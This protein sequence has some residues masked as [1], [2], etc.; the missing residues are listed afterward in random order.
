MSD[1]KVAIKLSTLEN[2]GNAVRNKEGTTD[3]IPVNT[4]A[5]RIAALPSGVSKL[6]QII[7]RTIT[8]ITAEDLVGIT[9]IGRYAFCDC[10]SLTSV[11]IPDS[12]TSISSYPFYNCTS[13]TSVTIGNGVTSIGDW[14]FYN[15]TSLMS[16]TI[17]DSVISIGG[18]MFRGCSS[19]TSVTIGNGVTSISRN[20]FDSCTSLTSVIIPDS[21][22]SISD[23]AFSYCTSLTS[24][25]IP[26]SVTSISYDAL[27][28]GSTSNTATITFLRT[29]PPSIASSTFRTDYLDKIIVP[30]G[31][32]EAYKTAT[33]WA[34]FA[35]Y[36]EEATE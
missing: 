34:N 19:L 20:M 12:V 26:D 6:P 27:K 28:I 16:V 10:A 18:Q 13:L 3:L 24:V 17:P 9:K 7:D 30:A 1:K 8:E 15:C 21:V 36:I 14:V 29:T 25:I 33:N 4:L 2:I 5:D 35:D 23:Y 11:I 31:C 22:T 32:G